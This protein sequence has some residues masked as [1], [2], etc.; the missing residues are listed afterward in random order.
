MLDMNS[1][2][3]VIKKMSASGILEDTEALSLIATNWYNVA[4]SCLVSVIDFIVARLFVLLTS[5][6]RSSYSRFSERISQLLHFVI[7]C[8]SD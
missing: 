2:Y 8:E 3:L 7:F 4:C 1:I 6:S 5:F